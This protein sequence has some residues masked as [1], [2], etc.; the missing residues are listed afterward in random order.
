[1]P[2]EKPRT[3]TLASHAQPSTASSSASNT[4]FD[5]LFA[6]AQAMGLRLTR[7]EYERTRA[8]VAAFL[9]AERLPT[10]GSSSSS[11]PSSVSAPQSSK[12]E[13]ANNDTH[14]STTSQHQ[15]QQRSTQRPTG[16]SFF[17]AIK[18]PDPKPSKPK[19]KLEDISSL[20]EKRRRRHRNQR[21]REKLASMSEPEATPRMMSSAS[22]A[23]TA[24]GSSGSFQATSSPQIGLGLQNTD[25]SPLS[26][27]PRSSVKVTPRSRSLSATTALTTSADLQAATSESLPGSPH[28]L[29]CLSSRAWLSPS[30]RLRLVSPPDSPVTVATRTT[31]AGSPRLT[32][33]DPDDSGIVLLPHS[34]DD[35]KIS[36]RRND[37]V[38]GEGFAGAS[39]AGWGSRRRTESEGS[40][41]MLASTSGLNE[42]MAKLG[43]L[44]RV[45]KDKRSPRRLRTE[46]KNRA[47]GESTALSS[48]SLVDTVADQ[49]A[50]RASKAAGGPKAASQAP[51]STEVRPGLHPPLPVNEHVRK[52]THS[53]GPSRSHTRQAS[54]AGKSVRW[55]SNVSNSPMTH[56]RMTTRDHYEFFVH[57]IAPGPT[58][59]GDLEVEQDI[60]TSTPAHDSMPWLFSIHSSPAQR[61]G[62]F[63]SDDLTV[64]LY[65]NVDSDIE[66]VSAS[67]LFNPRRGLLFTGSALQQSPVQPK[68]SA[69]TVNRFSAGFSDVSLSQS[70]ARPTLTQMMSSPARLALASRARHQRHRSGSLSGAAD[71]RPALQSPNLARATKAASAHTSNGIGFISPAA[72]FGASDLSS[73]DTSEHQPSAPFTQ[74]AVLPEPTKGHRRTLT[75]AQNHDDAEDAD[76]EGSANNSPTV[77]RGPKG[78]NAKL[79]VGK[80][81]LA[82]PVAQSDLGFHSRDAESTSRLK[83]LG[84]GES[85]TAHESKPQPATRDPPAASAGQPED[86]RAKAP[87]RHTSLASLDF[88]PPNGDVNC[89]EWQRP[90]HSRV[91]KLISEELQAAIDA[92]GTFQEP[93]PRYFVL[94]PGAGQTKAKPSHV[95][96]AGLIGQAILSSSDNRLSLAEIY[97]WISTVHPFFERGDRGWQNSIRHNLSLNKSFLKVEREAHIP[98][99]GGWWAI[100]PGHEERFQ[101]G[102]YSAAPSKGTSGTDSNSSKKKKKSTVSVPAMTGQ[103]HDAGEADNVVANDSLPAPASQSRKRQPTGDTESPQASPSRDASSRGGLSK[104]E[105]RKTSKGL[106]KPKLGAIL[107]SDGVEGNETTTRRPPLTSL[108]NRPQPM[109]SQGTVFDSVTPSRPDQTPFLA[110]STH[111]GSQNGMP[112]LTDSASSPPSS[113][114]PMSEAMMPPPSSLGPASAKKK[115][116]I[117][118]NGGYVNFNHDGMFQSSLSGYGSNFFGSNS[119]YPPQPS[120]LANRL[121]GTGTQPSSTGSPLRRQGIT[122]AAPG[123]PGKVSAPPVSSVRESSTNASSSLAGALN[124]KNSAMSDRTGSVGSNG[125]FHAFLSNPFMANRASPA[126]AHRGGKGVGGHGLS[127]PV[128]GSP[129]KM[130]SPMRFSNAGQSAGGLLSPA[131]AQ[132]QMAMQAGGSSNALPLDFNAMGS[133][134]ASLGI[135]SGPSGL[136]PSRVTPGKGGAGVSM[137]GVSPSPTTR[138]FQQ[139]QAGN[140]WLDDPFDY[141]GALQHELESM[142]GGDAVHMA[143]LEHPMHPGIGLGSSQHLQAPSHQL[144][145]ASPGGGAYMS[146]SGHSPANWGIMGS[147]MGRLNTAW[148]SGQENVSAVRG[149][150]GDSDGDASR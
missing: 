105:R 22:P 135:G 70:P 66:A 63:V 9:K 127:S 32:D 78:C 24:S 136:T 114:P 77:E 111:G 47:K 30:G 8:G 118:R 94:P 7:Q 82:R 31:M 51:A 125:A 62:S 53:R 119:F 146:M 4:E 74:D 38:S 45:M 40:S 134:Y 96:Y 126:G 109:Y 6:R 88:I 1:M 73:T 65:S 92:G 69:Q 68:S 29:H 129:M 11:T 132:L 131:G 116:D 98:G 43:L 117:Q 19:A 76:G 108:T 55:A 20:E 144:H 39:Q 107:S 91:V 26:V 139:Q 46:A 41:V 93:P 2:T 120:P 83:G 13:Q 100:K 72:L 35:V 12:T 59:L 48:N 148:L 34:E 64:D 42:G 52:G 58:T 15:Q 37:S 101:N 80:G 112:M 50:L 75:K 115:R 61:R 102:L 79:L 56:E 97:Q 27:F 106:K 90:D 25:T 137:M 54:Q 16:L 44:E 121:R 89:L 99:K 147:N 143:G 149:G 28:G 3:P 123:S 110:S 23:L 133:N 18:R 141:Q 33:I 103:V 140:G 14:S 49:Q 5:D 60:H 124:V 17:T 10:G 85:R 84:S 138:R 87:A 122:M 128:R 57:G 67:D 21:L 113:P 104:S 86:N 95:S 71:P 145:G 81:G 36:L 130:G 150:A 142:G